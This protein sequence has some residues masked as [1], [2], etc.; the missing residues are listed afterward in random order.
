MMRSPHL[1]Q[2]L[3][4][5]LRLVGSGV[6]PGAWLKSPRTGS[7]TE[8]SPGPSRLGRWPSGTRH[9]PLPRIRRHDQPHGAAEGGQLT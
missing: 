3:F 6:T 5:G 7:G 2:W 1:A 9:V 8:V 4:G